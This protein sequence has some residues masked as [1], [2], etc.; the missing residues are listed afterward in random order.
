MRLTEEY[1][2]R[3]IRQTLNE[4]AGD[5]ID[6]FNATELRNMLGVHDDDELNTAVQTEADEELEA[7]IART[8]AN[9]FGYR[10]IY[11]KDAVFNFHEVW[12]LL[13]R[14]YGFDYHGFDEGAES[15]IFNN[16]EYE[17]T[18]YPKEF[19]PRQA[20]FQFQNMH[21][22]R[23][24]GVSEGRIRNGVIKEAVR[25]SLK[26]FLRESIMDDMIFMVE[27]GRYG[28]FYLTD[29]NTHLEFMADVWIDNGEIFCNVESVS[30]D[31]RS[32]QIC[33]SEEFEAKCASAILQEEPN[34]IKGFD[35]FVDEIGNYK[36]AIQILNDTLDGESDTYTKLNQRWRD[37]VEM[38]GDAS[39]LRYM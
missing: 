25:K 23:V 9:S 20:E 4:I 27:K 3:V 19:Y 21:L 10:R 11:D 14:L 18:I 12:D 7:E 28:E 17:L 35:E 2:N 34:N 22:N 26:N 32:Q 38:A 8:I 36:E 31:R 30:D 29:I 5:E 37:N 6:G 33:D 13:K 15:H 24:R 39:S 16:G 1:I